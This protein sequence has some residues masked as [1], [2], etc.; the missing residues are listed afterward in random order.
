MPYPDLPEW[1]KLDDLGGLVP[2]EVRI[3]MRLFANEAKAHAEAETTA[4]L[5][6]AALWLNSVMGM[7]PQTPECKDMLTRLNA[8]V[9]ARESRALV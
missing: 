8:A 5:K 4:L 2:S 7:P 3:A 9:A 1:T 6:E